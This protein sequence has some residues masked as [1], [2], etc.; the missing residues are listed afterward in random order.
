MQKDLLDILNARSGGSGLQPHRKGGA[1]ANAIGVYSPVIDTATVSAK[2]I[3]STPTP[4]RA[5][6]V[7]EPSGFQLGNYKANPLVL[8]DHGFGEITLPIGKSRDP[9]GKLTVKIKSAS[10]EAECYFAQS[11]WQGMQVF[12]LVEEGILNCASVHIDP[13][14]ASV[15]TGADGRRGLHITKCDLLEWSIVGIPCNPEAVRKVLDRGKLAER[16]IAKP[17]EKMLKQYAAKPKGLV[18]GMEFNTREMDATR[19]Y[20]VKIKAENELLCRSFAKAL[21]NAMSAGDDDLL[22]KIDDLKKR[23]DGEAER[24]KAFPPRDEEGEDQEKKPMP[25]EGDAEKSPEAEGK[26]APDGEA[27]DE[28]APEEAGETPPAEGDAPPQAS[29]EQQDH[30]QKPGA[31]LASGIYT[32]VEQFA[33]QINSELGKQE[34]P[35]I[36]GMAQ[37]VIDSLNTITQACL[38]GYSAAYGGAMPQA[39]GM[40]QPAQSGVDPQEQQAFKRF[41]MAIVKDAKTPTPKKTEY[42]FR[43]IAKGLSDLSMKRN[44]SPEEIHRLGHWSKKLFE[45]VDEAKG[46]AAK[47]LQ[48]SADPAADE[49]CKLAAELLEQG[50][51]VGEKLQSLR[52]A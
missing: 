23:L 33:Q 27:S 1:I 44:L 8:Y 30:S 7:V 3:I 26:P 15:R 41:T 32:A 14:E 34:N 46:E 36:Q 39:G 2:F 20:M 48:A 9:D 28:G 12:Q 4:D 43:A 25:E 6:D 51:V 10:V 49:F 5:E 35:A 47:S 19:D 18:R 17:I 40:Q 52:I 38:D 22:G 16:K 24:L 29:G 21:E 50:K 37:E 45:L 31:Q 11:N 42:G 13:L